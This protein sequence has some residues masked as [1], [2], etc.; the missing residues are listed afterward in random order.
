MDQY[1]S[2]I[3]TEVYDKI[4]FEISSFTKE[5]E[6]KD[7]DASQFELNGRHIIS[8]NAKITPKKT[9]QF[10]T[11]WKR[12]G[13]GPI[14]PFSE[15]D[16]ID[17][18]TVNVRNEYKFGQFVF[19]KS[20]LIKKGII[21]TKIK[22]GKRAFRVYPSWN[23]AHNKQAERTQIWQLNYFYEINN[24]MDLNRIAELYKTE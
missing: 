4:D 17:F 22:E 9:G 10:V 11:F 3:K 2:Q 20:V 12:N 14:E 18:Y 15:T 24:A 23:L 7:Y 6:S 16:R 8:R 19:P 21:S 13:N 1:L 5:L